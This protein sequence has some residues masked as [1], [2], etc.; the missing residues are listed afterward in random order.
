MGEN[1]D[2]ECAGAL[3]RFAPKRAPSAAST[4]F[5]DSG[6]GGQAP[7]RRSR[8]RGH[9][10]TLRLSPDAQRRALAPQ[11]SLGLP[12]LRQ[13]T[14]GS[15]QPTA[16]G[17][18]TLGRVERGK[19][20]QDRPTMGG[21]LPGLPAVPSFVLRNCVPQSTASENS[22]TPRH[23]AVFRRRRPLVFQNAAGWGP[24]SGALGGGNDPRSPGGF[25]ARVE[26]VVRPAP[27]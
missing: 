10:S 21:A 15:G 1:P 11:H 7:R 22:A 27:H 16:A 12:E 26:R 20:H 5:L 25:V 23:S 2:G 18:R 13:G 8:G 3:A 17:R 9:L 6:N 4:P 14:R 19:T 24:D